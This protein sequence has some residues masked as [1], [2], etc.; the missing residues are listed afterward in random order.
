MTEPGQKD[1]P[2][3]ISDATRHPAQG[4]VGYELVLWRTLDVG[5]IKTSKVS[6]GRDNANT[7]LV[8]ES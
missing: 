4:V 5:L 3:Y 2:N 1:R 6:K 7:S 8:I